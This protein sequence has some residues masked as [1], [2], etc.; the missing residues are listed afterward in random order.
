MPP[1]GYSSEQSA[2]IVDFLKSCSRALEREG[3]QKQLSPTDALQAECKNIRLIL[4]SDEL[5]TPIA[6]LA[7]DMTLNLYVRLHQ[8]SPR[9]YEDLSEATDRLL[10]E[11]SVSILAIHVPDL[12]DAVESHQIR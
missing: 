12:L 5:S 6:R 4:E 9:D 11:V 10:Q 3:K 8:S 2:S 1:S 7:L